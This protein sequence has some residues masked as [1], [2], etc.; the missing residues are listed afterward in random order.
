[1]TTGF[2]LHAGATVLCVHTGQ[3]QPCG[4]SRP[5]GPQRQGP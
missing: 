2:L 3:A 4:L 5:D 1:M